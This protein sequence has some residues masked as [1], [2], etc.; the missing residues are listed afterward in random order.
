MFISLLQVTCWSSL[1]LKAFALLLLQTCVWSSW[2][3]ISAS[4]CHLKQE[5]AQ[6]TCSRRIADP[7][8][9]DRNAQQTEPA[10]TKAITTT[11]TNTALYLTLS[12]PPCRAWTESHL[13]PPQCESAAAHRFTHVA[14]VSLCRA[15]FLHLL[16]FNKP[17]LCRNR[18]Q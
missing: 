14:A 10:L 8:I 9:G 4:V 3:L 13:H 17:F 18:K 2:C 15:L 6:V 12:V 7:A 11:V 5:T 1:G 16:S